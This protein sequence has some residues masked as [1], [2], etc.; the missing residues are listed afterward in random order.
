MT[1]APDDLQRRRFLRDSARWALATAT[2]VALPAAAMP[3]ARDERLPIV[4]VRGA[5]ARPA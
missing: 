2:L 3:G 1:G 4:R 5:P